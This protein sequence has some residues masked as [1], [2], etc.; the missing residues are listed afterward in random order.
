MAAGPNS[1]SIITTSKQTMPSTADP[2][3]FSP[4]DITTALSVE[5]SN[6]TNTV[7]LTTQPDDFR[8]LDLFSD[9]FAI[10]Q[11]ISYL[12]L[13]AGNANVNQ[14]ITDHTF[15]TQIPAVTQPPNSPVTTPVVNLPRRALF[16]ASYSDLSH[17]QR[18]RRRDGSNLIS[19]NLRST[20]Q[21]SKRVKPATLLL[22]FLRDDKIAQHYNQRNGKLLKVENTIHSSLNNWHDK[23]KVSYIPYMD[24]YHTNIFENAPPPLSIDD[25]CMLLE[26]YMVIKPGCQVTILLPKN[27]FMLKST[28]FR[29]RGLQNLFKTAIRFNPFAPLQF[30]RTVYFA[31]KATVRSNVFCD[32]LTNGIKTQH[33]TKQLM[34]KSSGA[35]IT[36]SIKFGTGARDI[37]HVCLFYSNFIQHPLDIMFWTASSNRSP[38]ARIMQLKKTSHNHMQALYL[39][40]LNVADHQSFAHIS[41]I[42]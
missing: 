34:L 38:S 18:H 6:N 39:Y 13:S 8:A 3:L 16:R 21:H 11:N 28:S 42:I 19:F 31:I 15:T 14:H 35:G 2:N 30:Q 26:D 20:F 29:A 37:D 22:T 12:S 24:L 33:E 25:G 5:P 32:D 41:F 7:P 4:D 23:R 17:H 9:F 36:F 1:L 10:D 27:H 40:I